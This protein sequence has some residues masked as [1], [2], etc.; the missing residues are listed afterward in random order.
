V[1]ARVI[2]ATAGIQSRT[3]DVTNLPD[4]RHTLNSG[5]AQYYAAG[6]P[7][8]PAD[9]NA[10]PGLGLPTSSTGSGYPS[11]GGVTSSTGQPVSLMNPY[12]T[13]NYII[14]TGVIS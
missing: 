7:G 12:Q 3:L 13:I 14:F 6:L 10:V 4:H 8:A 2:G 5:N 1:T 9:S 11:S